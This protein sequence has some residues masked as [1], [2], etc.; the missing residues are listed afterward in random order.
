[1]RQI[2][3]VFMAALLFLGGAA[4]QAAQAQAPQPTGVVF[5]NVRIFDGTTDRLSA[6]TNVLVVGNAIKAISS[7]PIADPPAMSLT[8]LQ[9][10]GR[11][12]MPGLIDA[13]THIM[14][15]S[16]S[17]VEVL[18]GDIGFVN[19]AA[20]KAATDMLMRGFT[21]IRDLGGPAF[22]LKRGIDAGLVPGPRIWPA[23]AFIWQSGG[24][25]D[26]RLPSDLPARPGD[27]T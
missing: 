1:M 11:T 26:F 10:G 17:Q 25:G 22:G 24:H 5:E 6:P 13:H 2:S 8:Q 20:V 7:A 16:I 18:T 14:F 9:G 23:G 4:P 12:L 21:S 19:V 15:E 27:F 3:W